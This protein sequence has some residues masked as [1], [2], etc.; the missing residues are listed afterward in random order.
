MDKFSK[1]LHIRFGFKE[2][3]KLEK[4]AEY[5]KTSKSEVV[6]TLIR[7]EYAEIYGKK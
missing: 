5:H 3:K 6:R 1:D 2:F 7:K 4:I